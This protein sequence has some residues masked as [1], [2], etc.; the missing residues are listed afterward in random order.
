[1]AGHVRRRGAH[2]WE[3]KYELGTDTLTG[4]RRIR[5]VAFKGTKRAAELELARLVAQN[6]SGEGIDPSGNGCRI[7]H[8]VGARLGDREC[9]PKNAGTI[10]PIATPLCQPSYWCSTNTEAARGAS[11]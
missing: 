1:M 3:L 5:Y 8:A 9:R 6:A 2:S 10:S 4:Q 7:R 11:K